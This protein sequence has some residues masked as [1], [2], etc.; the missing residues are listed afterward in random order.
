MRRNQKVF[1]LLG[2]VLNCV[3]R[4]RRLHIP[5]QLT[6]IETGLQNGKF[7]GRLMSLLK[8]IIF[9]I[10]VLGYTITALLDIE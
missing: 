6:P 10:L 8:Y 4:H 2:S 1:A 7:C 3:M 5:G 9:I